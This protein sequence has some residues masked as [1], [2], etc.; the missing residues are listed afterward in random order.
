MITDPP[1]NNLLANVD[2]RYTLVIKVSKRARQLVAGAQPL[3]NSEEVKPVSLAVQEIDAGY[4]EI[5]PRHE[6]IE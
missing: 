2:C 6:D 4:V 3:I 5:K 1:I